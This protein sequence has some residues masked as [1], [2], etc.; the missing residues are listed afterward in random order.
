MSSRQK[1]QFKD[2]GL[3]STSTTV[4]HSRSVNKC[5]PLAPLFLLLCAWQCPRI[6]TDACMAYSYTRRHLKALAE[7]SNSAAGVG[8]GSQHVSSNHCEDW[9]PNQIVY[10]KV[11]CPSGR[12]QC[13]P[14]NAPLPLLPPLFADGANHRE[15]A[16]RAG[17]RPCPY[18]QKLHVQNTQR[19][20]RYPCALHSISLPLTSLLTLSF[21]P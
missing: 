12:T 9:N 5:G 14:L 19:L 20:H 17:W 1:C 15:D 3:V 7:A 10:N 4:R 13:R 6:R 21:P 11:S 16:G 8:D 2:P 18:R